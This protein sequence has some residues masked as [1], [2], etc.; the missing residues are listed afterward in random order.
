MAMTTETAARETIHDQVYAT[1]FDE[2]SGITIGL[3]SSI[4][5]YVT[6][7]QFEKIRA[8]QAQLDTGV[9]E[10]DSNAA[11]YPDGLFVKLD[12]RWSPELMALEPENRG[13]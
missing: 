3:E 10:L 13:L 11:I 5:S 7:G 12:G 1:R 4:L 6:T 8:N 9:V 2:D